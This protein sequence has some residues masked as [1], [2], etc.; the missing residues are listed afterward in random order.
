MRFRGRT[1]GLWLATVAAFVAC[2]GGV[3]ASDASAPPPGAPDAPVATKGSSG[4]IACDAPE[5]DWGSV[6]AGTE[7]A[8]TFVVK[9]VGDGV[10]R[11]L[12]ARGG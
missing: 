9:N 5:F 12:N 10:L 2:K 8:H 7:V 3:E 1:I 6:M 4:K 11:I